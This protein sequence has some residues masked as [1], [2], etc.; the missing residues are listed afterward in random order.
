MNFGYVKVGACSPEIKVADVDFNTSSILNAIEESI[1]SGVKLLVFPSL[2]ISGSTC[3]DLFFQD[4]L[5]L[6]CKNALKKI[7]E[8]TIDKNIIV[9]V[10][11]P[12]MHSGRLYDAV[13]TIF[14]GKV[15]GLTAKKYFG[16]IESGDYRYFSS[17]EKRVWYFSF[18]LY[19][20]LY[21]Q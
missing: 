17:L 21:T 12:L 6:D 4:K 2:C 10:G 11:L 9:C 8:Q 18:P 3:G 16:N 14:D 5:I 13:A 7:A 20:K 1:K 19:C 15:L